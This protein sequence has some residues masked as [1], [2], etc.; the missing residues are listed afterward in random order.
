M[1]MVSYMQAS[2]YLT[3]FTAAVH[4]LLCSRSDMADLQPHLHMLSTKR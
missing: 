4:L 3:P 2:I 1:I